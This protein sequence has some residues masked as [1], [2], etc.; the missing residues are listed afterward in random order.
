MQRNLLPPENVGVRVPITPITM[1]MIQR[2]FPGSPWTRRNFLRAGAL[3]SAGFALGGFQRAA[4]GR[5]GAPSAAP[6]TGS[7]APASAPPPVGKLSELKPLFQELVREME[8]RVPY[9]SA[10]A[11]RQVATSISF[12]DQ[13]QEIDE[14]LPSEGAVFTVYNG[15]WLEESST[16]DLS[17]ANLRAV[18]MALAKSARRRPRGRGGPEIDPGEGGDLSFRTPCSKDPTAL[19]L[20]EQFSWVQELHRRARAIDTSLINCVVSYGQGLGEEVFVNRAKSWSQE[21]IRVRGVIVY[22]ATDG[23]QTTNNFLSRGG[24]G[25]LELLDLADEDLATLARETHA[26][27]EA[28]PVEAGSYE[29]VVDGDITGTLAHESFGHG[30]E[31]DMFLKER[32][33]AA[34]FVG[35]R[36]GSELVNIIDDPSLPQGFGSYFFDHEG[37]RSSPTH[38]VE[39]G[40][41]IRGLSDLMSATLLK[42]PRSANGRRQDVG[43]KAYA[44]MSNTF[45][46]GGGDSKESL[47]EGVKNGLYL[48]TLTHGMEDPKGWGIQ[49]VA[50][51]GEEIKDGRRTGR[52]RSPVGITGYVPEVLASVNGVSGD[53]FAGPGTCGK[54]HKEFVPVSTGGPHIRFT[55]R[56]G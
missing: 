8:K 47:I 19:P 30:V 12:D 28:K 3:T 15:A 7:A 26:L 42:V 39:N 10:L 44:R 35:K 16:S 50:H 55:A 54:G 6:T 27:L 13:T 23:R 46:T 32:A 20:K 34:Q 14:V 49:L 56:L 37:Q 18:A 31:L 4:A 53:F 17:P 11:V 45:F 5:A 52:L 22:F 36:V 29:V 25:G 21:I 2:A 48:R 1:P 43:R 41:F 40:I 9:A 38:I 51:I 33:L 24:T